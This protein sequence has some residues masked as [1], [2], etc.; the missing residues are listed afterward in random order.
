[1]VPRGHAVAGACLLQNP[2]CVQVFYKNKPHPLLSN[3]SHSH[4][5]TLY[6][7]TLR[8]RSSPSPK[9]TETST[10]MPTYIVTCK[11]DAT[12][13]QVDAAKKHAE[14]QGGKIGHSYNLIK[15]F[16]VDF[17]EDSISTL[18]SHEHIKAVEKDAPV[19]TQ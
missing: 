3:I 4:T 9:H 11:E 16:S 15:G 13:E 14:D 10:K 5:N 19:K 17:P 2:F 8:P 18:E 6:T 12:P 1:M 7:S